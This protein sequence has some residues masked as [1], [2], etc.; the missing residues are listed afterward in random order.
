[1]KAL[2]TA[3]TGMHAQQMAVDVIS[4]NIANANTTAFKSSRVAFRD[5]MYQSLQRE[6]AA[7]SQAGTAAPVGIDVGLGVEGA[8]TARLH[9]QGGLTR[10]E[11]DLD[12]AIDGAGY[13]VVAAPD[14]TETYTR[15]GSFGL[16]SEGQVVTLLGHE[17]GPGIVVPE[18]TQSIEIGED[19]EVLAYVEDDPEPVR[20]G[21]L[22][23]ATFV[24]QAGLRPIGNNLFEATAASGDPI[25]GVP[26]DPGFGALRQGYLENS[27]VDV[28]QQITDLIKA[29]RAYELNS[30]TIETADQMM[31]TATRAR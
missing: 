6:G 23:M 5:L 31:S 11:A 9:S 25:Q 28:I 24:N 19:G 1:M 16:S 22:T 8:G 29:Q 26:G 20:I 3:A 2:A 10:T 4:N 13:F 21:R 15:D 14:G 18:R 27:N 30:K 7:T 12:V 17:V